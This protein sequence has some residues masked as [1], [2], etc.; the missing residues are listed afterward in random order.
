[1]H[2]G[3]VCCSLVLLVLSVLIPLRGSADA[4]PFTILPNGDLE[5]DTAFT[6]GGVFGC[7]FPAPTCIGA[8]TNSIVVRSATNTAALTFL[9]VSATIPLI[10]NASAHVPLGV[11]HASATPGFTFPTTHPQ[12]AL[13]TLSIS[14]HQSSPVPGTDRVTYGFGPGGGGTQLRL[15]DVFGFGNFM[16]LPIGPQPPPYRYGSLVYSF[17]PF[18]FAIPSS[19]IVDVGAR[20]GATPEPTT[21]L[22][23]GT[24]MAGLGLIRWRRR[25]RG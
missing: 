23:F 15:T 14:L 18:P 6:T 10:A 22:L 25:S 19:G 20:L 3:R 7:T 8:G 13:V 21:L 24:T 17:D 9:G 16:Q 11:I 5:I 4:A 12:Q 2:L 1:M